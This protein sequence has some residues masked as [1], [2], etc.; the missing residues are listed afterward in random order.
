MAKDKDSKKGAV[1][2]Q[3]VNNVVPVK[4]LD[5][6]GVAMV[7]KCLGECSKV[8]TVTVQLCR[9]K[10]QHVKIHTLCPEIMNDY[11]S[12]MGGVDL[13]DQKNSCLQIG[14]QVIWWMLLPQIIFSSDGYLWC[15]FLSNLQ[16]IVPKGNG[17]TRIRNCSG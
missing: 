11:N 8:S 6:H 17:I 2:F 5:N 12:S 16:S 13:I 15:K 14:P 1:N 9:V 7:G 10:R 3:Y 4:W